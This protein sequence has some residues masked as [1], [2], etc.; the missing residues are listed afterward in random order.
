MTG[1]TTKAHIAQ[2]VFASAPVGTSII[3]LD[4]VL[5]SKKPV[6]GLAAFEQETIGVFP[7][8][9]SNNLNITTKNNIQDVAIY[10]ALGQVVLT[11]TPNANTVNVDITSLP[12]GFYTV[13]A[14]ING[15]DTFKKIIKE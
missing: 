1:L 2:L 5:F 6:V 3:Y 15:V 7:N 14:S 13:K 12:N 10:N 9:A 8:P 11:T 4:N